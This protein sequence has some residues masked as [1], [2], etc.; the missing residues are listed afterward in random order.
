ME[1]QVL[2]FSRISLSAF[3]CYGL[4]AVKIL[5]INYNLCLDLELAVHLL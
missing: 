5:P 3:K 1:V 2:L 4:F